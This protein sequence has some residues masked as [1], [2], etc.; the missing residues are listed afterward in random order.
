MQ[1]FLVVSGI[2]DLVN[3]IG[4]YASD[5]FWRA[6]VYECAHACVCVRVRPRVCMCV[7]V[8]A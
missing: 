3:M 4:G 7:C 2:L 8:R 1:T 5:S 6:C